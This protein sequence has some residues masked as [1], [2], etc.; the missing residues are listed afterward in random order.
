M[1]N[2]KNAAQ[3]LGI[4]QS[5]LY[6]LINMRCIAHYR[7]GGKVVFSETDI[8]AYLV[9]C[10]VGAAATVATAPHAHVKLKHLQLG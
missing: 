3:R 5:K 9:S 7:I 8:D 1:I 4:S 10:R 2:V 6:Q